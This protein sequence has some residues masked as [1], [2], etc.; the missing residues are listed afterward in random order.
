MKDFVRGGCR[1]TSSLSRLT[2][3]LPEAHRIMINEEIRRLPVVDKDGR[4]VGSSPSAISAAP[5][6]RPPLPSASG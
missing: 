1:L 6:P 5:N 2:L 3:T 4:L